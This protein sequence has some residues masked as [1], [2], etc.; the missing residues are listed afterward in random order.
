MTASSHHDRLA[1]IVSDF[2]ARFAAY[3]APLFPT[4]ERYLL[5]LAHWYQGPI[6]YDHLQHQDVE[7]RRAVEDVH[8]K[9]E[10][11]FAAIARAFELS[12]LH[13]EVEHTTGD[14]IN[15]AETLFDMD[16]TEGEMAWM[17]TAISMRASGALGV[18]RPPGRR[19]QP[20]KL[21]YYQFVRDVHA[22][23]QARAG[24]KGYRE[25]GGS[26]EGPFIELFAEAQAILP[27]GMRLKERTTIANRV[28]QAFTVSIPASR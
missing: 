20:P 9:A 15:V 1:E 8:R 16:E 28:L 11:L 19:G 23:Y 13:P 26:A 17:V 2:R 10:E 7:T 4:D 5:Q 18:G 6:H 24:K 21:A 25:I 3:G 27:V 14:R 12:G 22:L